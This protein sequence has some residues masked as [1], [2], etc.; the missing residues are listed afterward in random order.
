VVDDEIPTFDASAFFSDPEN[1]V[2]TFIADQLPTG[3]ALDPD[4][5]FIDGTPTVLETV[6]V[7]IEAQDAE[8]STT[9]VSSNS[10]EITIVPAEAS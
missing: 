7:V 2:L 9:S 5:G 3:L 4:S 10:F 6:S 1:D 8:G